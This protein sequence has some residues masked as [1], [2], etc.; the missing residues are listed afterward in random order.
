MSI[1]NDNNN[2]N[3]NNENPSPNIPMIKEDNYDFQ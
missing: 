2:N 1:D 3:N